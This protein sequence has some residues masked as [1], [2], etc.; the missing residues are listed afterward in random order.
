MPAII[1]EGT[2]VDYLVY[3]GILYVDDPE[4]DFNLVAGEEIPFVSRN[5]V[6]I[7]DYRYF[8]HV[9]IRRK[10]LAVVRGLV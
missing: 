8:N 4:N 5:L 6:D 2:Q 7:N 3:V 1:A 9:L 10:S